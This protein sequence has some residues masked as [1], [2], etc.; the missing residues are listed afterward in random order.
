MSLEAQ[1]RGGLRSEF[2]PSELLKP[3]GFW[4]SVGFWLNMPK[5]HFGYSQNLRLFWFFSL[6]RGPGWCCGGLSASNYCLRW[7]VVEPKAGA[8]TPLV[9]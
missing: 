6:S 2:P 8:R 9:W 3:V 5:K 7:L 1:R 4:F